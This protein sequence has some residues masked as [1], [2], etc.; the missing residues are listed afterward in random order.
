[1]ARNLRAYL[2]SVV[3]AGLIM[4][5]P[6]AGVT[7]GEIAVTGSAKAKVPPDYATLDVNMQHLAD[8]GGEA[9]ERVA[10]I[11][12]DVMASLAKV[13]IQ[14][15]D[16]TTSHYRVGPQWERVRDKKP[17]FL[18][19]LAQHRLTVQIRDMKLVGTV[20]DAVIGAG[21]TSVGDVKFVAEYADSLQDAVLAA[22]VRQA[23]G[24][25]RTIA[26][27]AGGE[28]G[29]VIEIST[30]SAARLIKREVDQEMLPAQ[31]SISAMS[32]AVIPSMITVSVT[33]FGRWQF[34]ESE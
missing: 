26:L 27:S 15:S 14:E 7:G 6:V 3:L 17:K 34:V 24:R 9:T 29:D 5:I 33:I 23:H 21:A 19:Y 1:M 13:G 31:V 16:V 25:A 28:L 2:Q 32:T 8:R 20:V 10:L 22:A 18:G 11:H 30:S 12:Q 4:I